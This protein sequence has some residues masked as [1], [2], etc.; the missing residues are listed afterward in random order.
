M[1]WTET[2]KHEVAPEGTHP[3]RCVWVIDLGTQA[4][5]MFKT[6]ARKV[7]LGWELP[8][9]KREDG[10]PF[11]VIGTFTASLGEKAGLR[12]ALVSWRGRDFTPEEL[13]GFDSRNVLDR[14]CMIQVG[15]T[16]TGNAKVLNVM[17]LPKG[18]TVP[19]RISPTIYF[20]LD[21]G[22]FDQ[23]VLADIPE[24]FRKQIEAS[25]EYKERMNPTEKQPETTEP[26]AVG[27]ADDDIP[28]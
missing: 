3:G 20:S 13:A 12:K 2:S 21:E 9:E 19:P 23:K 22:M 26:E 14:P 4:S 16:N 27:I 6:K 15:R 7:L 11:V 24:L 17:A 28:F 10:N 8:N 18:M 25:P 1:K 5:D